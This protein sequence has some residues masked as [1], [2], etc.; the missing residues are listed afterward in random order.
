M[1]EKPKYESVT[2]R[3]YRFHAGFG[4][5]SCPVC[6]NS[7]DWGV[8]EEQPAGDYIR[9]LCGKCGYVLD[10]HVASFDRFLVESTTT[11]RN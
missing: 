1:C 2:D 7:T 9:F 8:P 10:F 6:R 4:S 3:L 11:K 5:L